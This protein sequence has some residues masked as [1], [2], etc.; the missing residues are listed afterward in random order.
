MRLLLTWTLWICGGLLYL[1]YV[2]GGLSIGGVA[3]A[4]TVRTAY[5]AFHTPEERPAAMSRI[6]AGPGRIL[7]NSEDFMR[8][9][10]LNVIPDWNGSE[11][12][13]ILLLGIDQRDTERVAGIPTR[14]D[15]MS[16]LSINPVTKA[17]ALISFPRDLWVSIPGL[18][19]QRI[20]EAYPWGEVR[21]VE[22]GGPGLAART[23][24]QNFGLQINHY[25]IVNFSGFED[26]IN[27]LGGVVIDVPRPLADDTYPTENYGVQRIFFAPGPQL[28][29][30]SM[31]L[32]YAR[33]RHADS[34]FG[35]I[36]RQQQVLLGMRDRA[37][38]Q[39]LIARLPALVDQGARSVQTDFS[40][41]ELLSLGKLAT[42]IDTSTLTTVEVTYPLV[43]DFRGYDGAF[44]LLPD[45]AAI[46]ATIARALE[47]PPTPA[48]SPT[49]PAAVAQVN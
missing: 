23:I 37:L 42:Q 32:K 47:P 1:V 41:T 7:P 49:T 9:Q 30:G 36:R 33:T 48:P 14:S 31:A 46:R 26:L 29:D 25:A 34:D 45:K 43:R 24:E 2:G 10:M 4:S 17:A 11:R 20:N 40:P 27:M 28:M 39:N 3:F 44:L 38:R 15:T 8:Q 13:S 19:E 18:G 16:V 6:A 12:I 21:R 35:R 22:G 5:S